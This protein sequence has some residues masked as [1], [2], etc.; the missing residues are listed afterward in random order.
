MAPRRLVFAAQYAAGA[1]TEAVHRAAFAGALAAAGAVAPAELVVRP[2][3]A[4]PASVA[5]ELLRDAA[6]PDGV[7]VRVETTRSL[8]DLLP[9]AWL[10]VTAWSNS[11]FEAALMGVPALTVVPPGVDD[12][13]RFAD[14]GLAMHAEDPAQAAAVAERLLDEV[15]R[16][17]MVDGA[18]AALAQ[19]IGPADGRAAERVARLILAQIGAP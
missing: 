19:R 17:R 12:P 4:K 3:P 2:H 1:L 9:G 5:T 7:T 13:V 14:E 15:E 8:H 16:L 10:L 11:V 6:V 18:R